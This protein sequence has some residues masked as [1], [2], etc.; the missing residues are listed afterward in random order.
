MHVLS[1]NVECYKFVDDPCHVEYAFA[2]V[3]GDKVIVFGIFFSKLDDNAVVA[4]LVLI[5]MVEAEVARNNDRACSVEVELKI[6]LRAA[7]V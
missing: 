3:D 5:L 7:H 4:L 6:V 1:G 2:L